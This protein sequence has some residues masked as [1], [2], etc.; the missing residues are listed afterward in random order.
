MEGV[1]DG[2]YVPK[3]TTRGEVRESKEEEVVVD[4]RL[5]L[6]V[7]PAK[8]TEKVVKLWD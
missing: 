8:E 5:V 2:A 7:S 3:G 1:K 4:W 6:E